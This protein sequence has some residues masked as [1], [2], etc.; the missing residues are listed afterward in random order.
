MNTFIASIAVLG[1]LAGAPA[2]AVDLG[3]DDVPLLRARV[4]TLEAALTQLAGTFGAATRALAARLEAL[5]SQPTSIAAPLFKSG[6]KG[7]VV[8]EG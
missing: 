3:P 7:G 1:I 8:S 2:R 5:E 6:L 4:D